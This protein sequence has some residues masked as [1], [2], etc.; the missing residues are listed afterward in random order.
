MFKG[1]LL[2]AVVL[3][4]LVLDASR[5]TPMT[6]SMATATTTIWHYYQTY[7]YYQPHCYSV[8]RPVTIPVWDDYSGEYIFRTVYR[9]YQVCN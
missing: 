7:S 4:G 1:I 2:S 3:S 6:M 5:L 9:D 8:S